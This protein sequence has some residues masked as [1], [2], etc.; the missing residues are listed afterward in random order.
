MVQPYEGDDFSCDVALPGV[1]DL[2]VVSEDEH[3]LAHHRTRPF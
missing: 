2:D 3:V 1:A